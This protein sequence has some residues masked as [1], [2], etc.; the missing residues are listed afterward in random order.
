MLRDIIQGIVARRISSPET[1]LGSGIVQSGGWIATIRGAGAAGTY[2]IAAQNCRYTR[3]GTRIILDI[4]I[5][6]AASVT[7]GGTSYLTI[8]GAPFSKIANTLPQGAVQ[9]NGI[10]YTAGSAVSLSHTTNGTG[11]DLYLNETTNG[12]ASNALAIS[13]LGANDFIKGS[14]CFE[15]ADP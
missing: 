7:G 15:T 11:A 4:S 8:Q 6:M 5:T 13:G 14:I 1:A 12:A 9:L 3:I 10:G 2:E